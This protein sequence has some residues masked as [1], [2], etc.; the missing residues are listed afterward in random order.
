MKTTQ[1]IL[2]LSLLLYKL[3]RLEIRPIIFDNPRHKNVMLNSSAH[4]LLNLRL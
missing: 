1:Q 4:L 3:L 2:S